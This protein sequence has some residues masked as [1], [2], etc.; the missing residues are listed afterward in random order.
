MTL[1]DHTRPTGGQSAGSPPP[2]GPAEAVMLQVLDTEGRRRPQPE[3]DPWIED[4]DAAALAA[5][6]RQMAVVRRLDVEATHLQRQGELALWPPLL[7]Q[8]AAQVGSAVALRPDDFV[9]PSYRENG[10][11]LLRGVP[12]LDLLRVWRGSTFSS[13]DPNETR[14]ATQQIIIGAQALHAVGYAMGVQR[15]QADV[16]TIVYFGDGATSQGDVNEAMV[17]SASYQAPVVFFCQNNHWAISEPVRLQTRRSIADRPWGFGIPSMRVDG[18]DVLAVLAAT[19]AAV[20][21]AADGGGPTFVEAVTYRMG[22]H[23]TADDPTRYRDDAELEA[24]KARDPLTRVEAHLRTL[25]VDVDAVL[26]QAQAEADELAAEVRRALEALEEDGA[27]R[28]FD[29]IYAEPHQELERQRREHALYL[30]QFDDEE[31]GA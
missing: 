19:R 26:A 31:A 25:D 29:E 23:T 9:F 6:Y 17:F 14:V 7:G 13:W 15:D 21:R 20:E 18:N 28:L 5:L 12:A 10:V 11:A 27:D 8:E 3:L 1:V 24:W 16:A 4:V 22:P 2:A 30:Q